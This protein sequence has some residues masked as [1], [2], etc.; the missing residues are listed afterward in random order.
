M[1]IIF[2]SPE[3]D[4]AFKNSCLFEKLNLKLSITGL[5]AYTA[6]TFSFLKYSISKGNIEIV[7]SQY[8]FSVNILL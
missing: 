4:N 6:F 3:K 2:L 8:S 7:K 5:P 1:P